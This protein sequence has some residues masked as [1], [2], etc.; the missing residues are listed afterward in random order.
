MENGMQVAYARVS[1]QDQDLTIQR[2]RLAHC[3]KLFAETA[4]GASDHRPQLQACL[5]FLREGDTLVITRLDRLAR[6]T[7]HLCQIGD[8]LAQKGVHLTV[9][10]QP[11]DTH[12]PTGR[13]LFGML[14][15]IAQFELELRAERQ[16]EGIAKAQRA[17]VHFGRTKALTPAQA[18]TLRAQRA[19]GV[20][21]GELMQQ[22]GIGKTAVYRYLNGDGGLKPLEQALLSETPGRREG[23]DEENYM[24]DLA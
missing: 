14:S 3:E 5:D 11:L 17:G 7:L 15:V 21:L 24:N 4:G 20:T 6:S 18:A 19:A 8:L 9:L 1:T 10:D 23:L 16:R 2:N 22:Y 12:T 13:L